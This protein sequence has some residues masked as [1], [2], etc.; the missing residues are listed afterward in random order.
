MWSEFKTFVARGNVIDLAVGI[1]TIDP[2]THSM[3]RDR[4]A[5]EWPRP[6]VTP[7]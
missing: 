1:P 7:V 5:T 6:A 4:A 2:E 3:L